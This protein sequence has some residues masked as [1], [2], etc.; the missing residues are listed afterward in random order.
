MRVFGIVSLL[1]GAAW[2]VIALS[3]P[4]SIQTPE[5]EIGTGEFQISIP[6]TE[7]YNLDLANRRQTQ[8]IV[9]ALLVVV[10]SIFIGFGFINNSKDP[11]DKTQTSVALKEDNQSLF[12]AAE[13][14]DFDMAYGLIRDGANINQRNHLGKTAV[15]IAQEHG[16][17]RIVEL[18]LSNGAIASSGQ[19]LPMV[20]K[21]Y[22]YQALENYLASTPAAI[23]EMTLSF[24]QVESIIG[25]P[26]PSSALNYREWWAN[27]SDISKR[28]QA[29]A[30]TSAGFLVDEVHQMD[31]NSWVRFKRNKPVA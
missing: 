28:P 19:E 5:Q 8:L 21:P 9:A 22:K 2:V 4:T 31:K 26:L 24:D 12:Q 16:N 14:G 20:T 13:H 6:P 27:Q 3:L 30:W 7:V 15:D 1:I 25:D 17:I 23:D 29:K 10:G 18:L 11:M